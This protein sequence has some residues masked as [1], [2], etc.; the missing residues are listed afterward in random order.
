[1]ARILPIPPRP[2]D[3]NVII[4]GDEMTIVSRS[5]G[6]K[7][8][9]TFAFSFSFLGLEIGLARRDMFNVGTERRRRGRDEPDGSPWSRE[10]GDM[11]VVM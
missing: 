6:R 11:A 8:L 5:T 7:S 4:A 2:D 9:F 10:E 1:M 3:C